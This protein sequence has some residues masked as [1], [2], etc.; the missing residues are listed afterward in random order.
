MAIDFQA[1]MQHA[2]DA[3]LAAREAGEFPFAAVLVDPQG[4]IVRT[5]ADTIERDRDYTA[6][7][8]TMLIKEAAQTLGRDLTGY[9]VVTTTEPCPMCFTSCWLACCQRVVYGSTM[10][11]VDEAIPGQMRE[12][13]FPASKLNAFTDEPLELEGG[14]LREQCLAMFAESPA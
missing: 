12:L 11:E 4:Q 3:A 10:R 5:R 7:A 2:I 1:C 6:H 9:T 8:E 14:V 13:R